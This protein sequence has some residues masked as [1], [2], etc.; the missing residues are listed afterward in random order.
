MDDRYGRST[1]LFKS[2]FRIY[3]NL[4]RL[5]SALDDA[6]LAHYHHENDPEFDCKLIF[7]PGGHDAN[8]LQQPID[9]VELLQNSLSAVEEISQ[10][11]EDI[12]AATPDR[13]MTE[14]DRAV[15]LLRVEL[16]KFG[17]LLENPP[18]SE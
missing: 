1:P 5:R 11:R 13:H 2:S 12:A 9:A 14:V 6:V 8:A 3:R 18:P 7:Y 17:R 10:R 16:E 15:R 4:S